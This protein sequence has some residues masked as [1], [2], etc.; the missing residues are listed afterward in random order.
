[1]KK[2]NNPIVQEVIE[3]FDTVYTMT[4]SFVKN[5]HS[6]LKGLLISG[7]A[8]T[9]K[10]HFVK[11]AFIDTETTEDVKYVKGASISAAAL[12]VMLYMYRE[13]GK[14]VV[15]DDVDI[16]SKS[17]AERNAILDMMKGA[18]EVTKG[19]RNISWI[20]AQS[21]PLMVQNNVPITFNF[22]GSLIWITNETIDDIAKKAKNHWGAISSRFN[23]VKV[24]LT[25]EQKLMY[26]LFLIEDIN[27]LGKECEG[28]EG[29]YSI[30]VQNDTIDY[31]KDNWKELNEITPRLAIKIA[32]IRNNHPSNWKV[33]IKNQL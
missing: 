16:T 13:E 19:D 32:D 1:M 6:A 26:T 10:T 8:G 5:R 30:K 22:E 2:N 7:D 31:I 11:K 9:G 23:Q 17:P 14:V 21:N 24:Y 4:E 28:K 27:M 15:L 3:K 25:Q 12:Y 20:K 29:G 33:L 18:T